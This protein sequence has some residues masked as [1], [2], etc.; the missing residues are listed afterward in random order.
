M[1]DMKRREFMTL[2][3]GANEPLISSQDAPSRYPVGRVACRSELP[4]ERFSPMALLRPTVI[5]CRGPQAGGNPR[6]KRT[7]RPSLT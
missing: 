2:L 4:R 7:E 1:F 3:G 6:I 5:T